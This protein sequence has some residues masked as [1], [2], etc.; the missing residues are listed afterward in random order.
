MYFKE[1]SQAE[2]E[3]KISDRVFAHG[4]EAQ[5]HPLGA[6]PNTR[7]RRNFNFQLDFVEQGAKFSATSEKRSA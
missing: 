6:R 3:V 2:D 1:Y 4:A 7:I 5:S